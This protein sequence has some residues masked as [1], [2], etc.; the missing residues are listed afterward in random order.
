MQFFDSCVWFGGLVF[1][2]MLRSVVHDLNAVLMSYVLPT[3]L[4]FSDMSGAYGIIVDPV[5]FSCAV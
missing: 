1:V 4:N 5:G 2:I 3:L